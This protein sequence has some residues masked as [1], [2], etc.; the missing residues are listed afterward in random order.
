[1]GGLLLATGLGGL[2]GAASAVLIG[3]EVYALRPVLRD[4]VA[5]VGAPAVV[6]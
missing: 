1:M 4:L 5:A 6:T 3:V 2:S